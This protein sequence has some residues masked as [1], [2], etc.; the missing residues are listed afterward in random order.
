MN[1]SDEQ[2]CTDDHEIYRKFL[3]LHHTNNTIDRMAVANITKRLRSEIEERYREIENIEPGTETDQLN[4][5][6]NKTNK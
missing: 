1:L 6:H 4:E 5:S 2:N 3:P